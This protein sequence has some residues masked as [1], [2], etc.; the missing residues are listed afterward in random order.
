VEDTVAQFRTFSQRANLMIA[1]DHS[2]RAGNGFFQ[3]IFDQHPQVLTCPWIHYVYSYI[4]TEFGPKAEIDAA[5]LRAFLS[6]HAYFRL[7]Y[8]D[9]DPQRRMEILKF[10][11]NPEARIDRDR[12]RAVFDEIL[13][14]SRVIT[15]RDAVLAMYFAFG[16][17][18]G[19]I[20]D[21]VKYVLVTD[22]MSLRFESAYDG[23]SGVALEAAAA[24]FPAIRILQL[25]RDPRASFASTNHQFVN[26]AGNMYGLHFGNF[27]KSLGLLWRKKFDWE[28]VFV[29]GFLLIYF[30]QAYLAAERFK[31]RHSDNVIVIRNEDLNL[32]FAEATGALCAQLGIA[33]SPQWS[34]N[35]Y[36]P[37]MVGMPWTGTG[38]YNSAY[39][40]ITDG[41]LENDPPSVA[42]KV[43]G[44][45]EYVTR[46]WRSRLAPNE[47]YLIEWMLRDE[48]RNFGYEP[49]ELNADNRSVA[50]MTRRLRAPLRGEL[51]TWRWIARG[52]RR[53]FAEIADRVFFTL[54]FAPF[55][56]GVRRAFVKL[57]TTN[58]ALMAP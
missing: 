38:A 17:A 51:P 34:A 21:D 15:R 39:Q 14:R 19:R 16:L 45:N 30:R 10:G 32:K 42:D 11:G 24:D 52:G 48:L 9:A 12:L 50:A 26:S 13:G 3:A 18:T 1:I 33:P 22:A 20:L 23:F 41:P 35:D 53:G 40:K 58:P 28:R 44:P 43:T 8:Q 31:A 25:V 54:F 36:Q 46:R 7:L 27:W 29:F 2:G 37:T 4:V 47:I 57:V 6:T 5:Q 55:Y 56:V 49:M